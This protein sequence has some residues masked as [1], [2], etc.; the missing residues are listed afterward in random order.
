MSRTAQTIRKHDWNTDMAVLIV[1]HPHRDRC[2]AFLPTVKY[3]VLSLHFIS[4]AKP[5][6][7]G[8]FIKGETET[9]P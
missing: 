2:S 8:T 5:V 3:P 6:G 4:K 9:K 7:L 1:W